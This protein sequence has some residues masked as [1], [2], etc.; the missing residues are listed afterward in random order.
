M[1]NAA[2]WACVTWVEE[3]QTIF[4]RSMTCAEDRVVRGGVNG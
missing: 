3:I 2:R 4:G 1:R